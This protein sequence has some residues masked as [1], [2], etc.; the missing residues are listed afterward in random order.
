MGV[1]TSAHAT[2][3]VERRRSKLI[4][5]LP[6]ERIIPPW[7]VRGKRSE[8]KGSDDACGKDKG[9]A[10]TAPA[11]YLSYLSYLSYPSYLSYLSYLPLLARVQVVPVH[12]RVEAQDERTLRLPAPERA[13]GEHH[14]VALADR[15]VDDLRTIRQVLGAEHAT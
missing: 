12:E 11:P 8:V 10:L 4:G 9:P 15:R 13:D 5:C 6:N 1:A 7:Q 2:I 3:R 14:H